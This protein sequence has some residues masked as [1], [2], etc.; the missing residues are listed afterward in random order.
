MLDTFKIKLKACNLPVNI[1]KFFESSFFHKKFPVA[2]SEKFT[3]F[4]GK[5]QWRRRNSF[6]FLINKTE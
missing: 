4:P 3:N 1:A 6:I 2:A 5:Y